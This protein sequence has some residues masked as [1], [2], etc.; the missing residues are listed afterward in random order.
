LE[1]IS[2]LFVR[3]EIWIGISFLKSAWSLYEEN[4]PGVIATFEIEHVWM[5]R[6]DDV[7]LLNPLSSFGGGISMIGEVDKPY[8]QW[9]APEFPNDI[10]GFKLLRERAAAYASCGDFSGK[11]AVKYHATIAFLRQVLGDDIYAWGTQIGESDHT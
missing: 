6:H 2:S 5:R 7:L 8:L 10:L 3:Q 1:R 9:D 11:E 4:N